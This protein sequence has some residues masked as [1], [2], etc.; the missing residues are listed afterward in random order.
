MGILK[1]QALIPAKPRRRGTTGLVAEFFRSP[2]CHSP[3]HF[4]LPSA[5]RHR[6]R[7][8]V[9]QTVG[10]TRTLVALAPNLLS[11][12][13]LV[14]AIAFA[15]FPP[16]WRAPVVIIAALTDVFDGYIARRYRVT[17]WQ[18]GLLDGVADKAF[19]L[20]VLITLTLDGELAW[21]ELLAV[22]LRDLVVFFTAAYAAAL[23]DWEAFHR[24]P[25][26]HFGKA[27]TAAIYLMFCIYLIWP[28]Q[29]TLRH[30]LLAIAI[31]F[32]ALAAGDY[33]LQFLRALRAKGR[34]RGTGDREQG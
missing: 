30:V 31:T 9:S 23:R 33:L 4:L 20:A 14:L 7:S 16:D 5:R 29:L 21:W 27:T 28:D 8:G 34:E 15:H 10:S 6:Y 25:A 19:V 32:S 1:N 11:A 13:R 17:S 18:G 3:C 22:L 24:M 2:V 12:A 26:R